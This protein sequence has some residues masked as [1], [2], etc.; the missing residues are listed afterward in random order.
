M[1]TWKPMSVFQETCLQGLARLSLVKSILTWP[2]TICSIYYHSRFPKFPETRKLVKTSENRKLNCHIA[3]VCEGAY[4][5]NPFKKWHK[6]SWK[7]LLLKN[8]WMSHRQWR[9]CRYI[10]VMRHFKVRRLHN[11]FLTWF[12]GCDM[13]QTTYTCEP[14]KSINFTCIVVCLQETNATVHP[15]RKS[16]K[17]SK[18]DYFKSL[19]VDTWWHQWYCNS[20]LRLPLFHSLPCF[21]VQST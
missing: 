4:G 20:T 3:D 17:K 11:N 18:V 5:F 19:A 21:C 15:E 7:N 1:A 2:F 12:G 13:K 9:N 16:W 10:D 14:Y 6:S 8:C